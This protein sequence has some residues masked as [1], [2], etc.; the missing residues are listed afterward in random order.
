MRQWFGYTTKWGD[1][2]YDFNPIENFTV[3][4]VLEIG[5]MLGV[6]SKILDKAPNDGLGGQT[7][8]EKMGVKYSQIAEMIE[9][10]NTD[11]LAKEKILKMYKASKHKREKIP[12][13]T[14]ERDNFLLKY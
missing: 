11:S 4:E 12:T 13:Y 7:D 2:S 3:S 10:G 14:F 1:S 8:E 9:T 5:R 6:P